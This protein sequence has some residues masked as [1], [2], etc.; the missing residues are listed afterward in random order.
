MKTGKLSQ[1]IKRRIDNRAAVAAE[2]NDRLNKYKWINADT[3]KKTKGIQIKPLPIEDNTKLTKDGVN[4]VSGFHPHFGCRTPQYQ[5]LHPLHAP[6]DAPGRA[7]HAPPDAPGRA[8]FEHK[9]NSD[10]NEAMIWSA[11]ASIIDKRYKAT[12]A[13]MADQSKAM[14]ASMNH[15]MNHNTA[16]MTKF[17]NSLKR[18]LDLLQLKHDAQTHRLAEVTSLCVQLKKA[19]PPQIKPK[20]DDDNDDDD[21]HEDDDDNADAPRD[22]DYDADDD[23]D[24]HGDNEDDDDADDDDDAHGDNVDDDDEFVTMTGILDTNGDSMPDDGK[25]YSLVVTKMKRRKIIKSC[26]TLDH[27]INYE[28]RS[29]K[30]TMRSNRTSNNHSPADTGNIGKIVNCT[31]CGESR[32]PQSEDICLKNVISDQHCPVKSKYFDKFPVVGGRHPDSGEK[33]INVLRSKLKK[34][35][36]M[37]FF[38]GNNIKCKSHSHNEKSRIDTY[39]NCAKHN[40]RKSYSCAATKIK[41]RIDTYSNCAKNNDRKSYLSLIPTGA[42]IQ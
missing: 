20:D 13:S 40:N 2:A 23:D 35:S 10:S 9:F 19:I 32:D 6:P 5:R 34:T 26:W 11:V 16:M 36:S 8:D 28:S 33:K 39:S 41:S 4:E 29:K 15:T 14:I 3:K 24:A 25:T 27:E 21:I 12:I 17:I 1:S 18:D 22:E 38:G 7:L 37:P 31:S 30:S 42:L